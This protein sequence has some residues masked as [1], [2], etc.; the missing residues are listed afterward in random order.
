MIVFGSEYLDEL[1]GLAK[2]SPRLRQHRNIHTSYD[3]PCQRL[4]NAIEPES[5][6]RPH[7]HAADPRDELS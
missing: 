7:R 3:D 2:V 5:Y 1:S 6:I 4:F